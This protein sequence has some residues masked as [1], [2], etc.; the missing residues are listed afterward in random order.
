MGYT[1][2][3]N[4]IEGGD[5]DGEQLFMCVCHGGGGMRCARFRCDLVVGHRGWLGLTE[6]DMIKLLVV[7]I[8][9][10]GRLFLLLFSASSLR[11]E[12]Y[13]LI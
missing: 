6:R 13:K 7:I 3:V 4:D 1:V 10:I 5:N 9:N 11:P 2:G 12:G 8:V